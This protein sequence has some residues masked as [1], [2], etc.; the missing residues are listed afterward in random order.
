MNANLPLAFEAST[1]LLKP[2]YLRRV[3]FIPLHKVEYEP[4]RTLDWVVPKTKKPPKRRLV[5][6]KY[7]TNP[8]LRLTYIFSMVSMPSKSIADF[9]VL[10]VN[11]VSIKRLCLT[12]SGTSSFN[13]GQA[14]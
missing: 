6:W 7:L 11:A 2:A 10:A 5:Y 9:N 1:T 8:E 4:C 13:I 3:Y 12:C 14:S